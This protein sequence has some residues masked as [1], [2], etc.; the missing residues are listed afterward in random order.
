MQNNMIQKIKSLIAENADPETAKEMS[1]YMQNRFVFAGIQKPRLMKLIS[2]FLRETTK[3]PLNWDLVFGLWDLE[4]R[5]A[6]YIALEYLKKHIRQIV[7]EDL[8]RL[9]A[10]ITGKSWW[11]TVDTL[12][13]FAGAAVMKDP[14]LKEVMV[15]W[16]SDENIWLRRTAID[17]QQKYKN[18]T[19]EKLLEKII[20]ANLGSRE[21]FINKAIGWSLR[22]YS[23]VNSE[24]VESFIEKYRTEL[25]PL[26]IKEASKY[27]GKQD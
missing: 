17:F 27:L 18:H 7:P 11:E 15:Q 5:E 8:D 16:A 4:Q 21:F 12:D 3:E 9:K 20:V 10:L 6:Q 22:E 25:A 26:S 23:K 19:D 14:G 1:A 2:P 13:A 24:W